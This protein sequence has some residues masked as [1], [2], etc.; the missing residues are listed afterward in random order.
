[1]K[2]IIYIVEEFNQN[3]PINY[4]LDVGCGEGYYLNKL[5]EK[6]RLNNKCKFVGIDISKEGVVVKVIPEENYLMEIR[7]EIQDEIKK[8]KYSN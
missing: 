1:M 2:D 4:V 8:E 6:D 3:T 5:S 7:N